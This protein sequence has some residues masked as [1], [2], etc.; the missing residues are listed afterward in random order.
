MVSWE[1]PLGL[2][3]RVPMS[4]VSWPCSPMGVLACLEAG[5]VLFCVLRI[6]PSGQAWQGQGEKQKWA[7]APQALVGTIPAISLSAKASHT[8][9]LS[10]MGWGN[11][12]C[13]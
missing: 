12:P 8:A 9:G 2:A 13:L 6:P 1:I 3:G 10:C 11:G 4:G 5:P 7:D